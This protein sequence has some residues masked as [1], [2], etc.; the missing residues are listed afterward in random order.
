M[1]TRRE[2]D[3]D[4]APHAAKWSANGT[5]VSR[6]TNV[7]VAREANIG[8]LVE[9]VPRAILAELRLSH[10]HHPDVGRLQLSHDLAEDFTVAQ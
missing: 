5:C 10:Q 2:S 4:S 7:H 1:T 9:P 8:I 3:G 6:A